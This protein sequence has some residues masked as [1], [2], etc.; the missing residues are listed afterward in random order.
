MKN[1]KIKITAMLIFT[2]FL[3]GCAVRMTDENKKPV[4]NEE[5]GQQLVENIYVNHRK[6]K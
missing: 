5:T 1:K 3:S 4:I 6:I 2:L